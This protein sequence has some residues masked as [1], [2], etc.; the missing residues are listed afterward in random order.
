MRPD[1]AAPLLPAPLLCP[2]PRLPL[3][4]IIRRVCLP[5]LLQD[6]IRRVCL[7]LLLLLL[8]RL[9]HYIPLPGVEMHRLPAMETASQGGYRHRHGWATRRLGIGR[10]GRITGQA[11]AHHRPGWG[12]SSGKQAKQ[13]GPH[14]QF[15]GMGEW[16]G[17]QQM[18]WSW[19]GGGWQGAGG[20]GPRAVG[21]E[22]GAGG[23]GRLAG[24]RGPGPGDDER[25]AEGKG[26]R[27]G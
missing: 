12:A 8:L 7:T 3:Q 10:L 25:G 5:L 17:G 16:V 15:P 21:R 13:A 14:Y 19:M 1:P 23:Q 20:R 11:G 6:I 24:S 2:A 27:V 26:V 18:Q 9:G 22:Q 4:V